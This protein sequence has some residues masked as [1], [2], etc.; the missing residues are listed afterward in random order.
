MLKIGPDSALYIT[1]IYRRV[2]EHPE[3]FPEELKTR[4]D[5]R[6]GDDK[7][8]IYRVYP[9][10]AQL[11]PIPRLDQLTVTDLFQRL[12]STNGWER[13]MAQRMLLWR[14]EKPP[15]TELRRLGANDPDPKVRIQV[16]STMDGLGMMTPQIAL[17]G[18]GDRHPAVKEIA[19]RFAEP[20]L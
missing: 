12:A 15:E 18:L 8:R 11:R 9:E 19:L 5:L 3:Y 14:D 17:F 13:D 20:F 2:I 16:L 10:G 4:P 7:G 6:A 1:D